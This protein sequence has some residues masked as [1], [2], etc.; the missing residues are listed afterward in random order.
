VSDLFGREKETEVLRQRLAKRKSF[1]LHG[2]AGVG[3][4][5]LLARLLPTFP[6]VLYC[7][8]AASKTSLFR[9]LATALLATCNPAASCKL[10]SADNIKSKSAVNLKG[11]VLDVLH[12]GQYS[13]VLD[14]LCQPSAPFASDIRDVANWGSIPVIGVARSPHMEDVGFLLPL[15]ADRQEKVELRNF[16]D[17]EARRFGCWTMARAGLVAGN[18]DDFL[19]RVIEFSQGNPGAII[20]MV[21]MAREPKYRSDDCIKITPL[22]VD[23]RLSTAAA[24][25]RLRT[26]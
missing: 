16:A 4:T 12:S 14:H 23:F 18:L 7:A 21:G 11:L 24:A 26:P 6:D 5:A 17:E 9:G 22:Y 8:E 10:K 13:V 20:S 2:P 19:E 25:S 3:K 15:F 1:L